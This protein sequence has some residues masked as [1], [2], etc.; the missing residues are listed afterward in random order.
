[1]AHIP[2]HLVL[3]RHRDL[4]GRGWH[5]W[6]RRALLLACLAVPGG[7]ALANVFGQRPDTTIA[8]APAAS[9]KVYAASHVRG[10][11]LFMGRFTI[12]AHLPKK[13]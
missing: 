12:D 2:D 10:G 8:A 6:L 3:R 5:V 4:V 7:L 13:S 11:L 1:M 9:V